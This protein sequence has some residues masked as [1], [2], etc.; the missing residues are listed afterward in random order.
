MEED[1]VMSSA[2]KRKSF[3][4]GGLSP[5]ISRRMVDIATFVSPR[6]SPLLRR[7]STSRLKILP[8]KLGGSYKDM[9]YACC[10]SFVAI[11]IRESSLYVDVFVIEIGMTYSTCVGLF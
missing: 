10:V 6:S 9:V 8:H 5:R 3:S 11:E 7:R 4:N 1:R 2:M